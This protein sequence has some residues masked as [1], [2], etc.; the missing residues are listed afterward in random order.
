MN[1]IAD[2]ETTVDDNPSVQRSTEVWSAAWVELDGNAFGIEHSITDFMKYLFSLRTN[3]NVWFHNLRFDGSF[4][5][6]W[7]LRSGWI[8]HKDTKHDF[9]NKMFSTLIT[10]QNRWYS[11]I[12]KYGSRTI[13]FKDSVKLIPLSL[14][15][16]GKAFDTKHRKT[17]MEYK[18]HRYAGCPIT[19]KEL[20]YIINDVM[21]LKEA[22]AKMQSEGHLKLTIGA[23]CVGEFKSYFTKDQYE[24]IFPDLT[25]C[26]TPKWIP[27]PSAYD[28]IIKSYKGGWSYLKKEHASK[29]VYGGKVYDVNSL[30]PSVMHSKSGN[31]Y[32]TGKPVFYKGAP[33]EFF[34]RDN[35]VGLI[36]LRCSFKI[37]PGYLPTIQ[38]KNDWRYKGTEWLETSALRYN[39]KD[40]D[41]YERDG[42]IYTPVVD[43]YLLKSD[44]K[45]L[46]EHYNVDNVE[47]LDGC[48]FN[49]II[50][51]FDEYIDKYMEI[52]MTT[53]D[54]GMRQIAKLFLNN[55]YG[56]LAT[57]KTADWLE[58]FLDS[59]TDSVQFSSHSGDEKPTISIINGSLVTAYA[60]YFTISHAQKNY[61]AFIYADTDSL[62]MFDFPTVGIVEH[63]SALLTWK[64]ES[65][66]SSAIFIRQKTYA[67]FIRK[68]NGEKVTPHWE[69]KC[70]GLPDSGKEKFL[71]MHPI[72]DFKIGL[73]IPNAKLKP[74]RIH[75]GTVLVETDFT[76]RK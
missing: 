76:L 13:T 31:Y 61:D 60:R 49:G 68:E 4:I 47:Y 8:F 66:W 48:Y 74:K 58:P 59:E 1:I 5:V 3:C 43:L 54:K 18:G 34:W 67:E 44:Y 75:G 32:A 41:Y 37:K 6:D 7:L 70:A 38:I 46:M 33:P 45:L 50:G 29:R 27:E 42:K 56:K 51:I 19:S 39:G 72:T 25:Q 11:I 35:I 21:V 53:K 62:H 73:F 10:S 23:C 40:Y 20:E 36:H 55:L 57:K 12:L 16:V 30:Y 14:E 28:Y 64:N 52:K 69:I 71:A 65:T 22:L 17:T 26:S 24:R 63:P 2:F 9:E 15:Q